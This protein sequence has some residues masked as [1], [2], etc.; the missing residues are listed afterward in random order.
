MH[1]KQVP[2]VSSSVFLNIL[3]LYNTTQRAL[4][5]DNYRLHEGLC[6]RKRLIKCVKTQ[7]PEYKSN[8]ARYDL[9]EICDESKIISKLHT[10]ELSDQHL[11]KGEFFW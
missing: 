8:N 10:T 5:Q 4:R 2:D 1:S 3:G 7:E 11:I 9:T 6:I